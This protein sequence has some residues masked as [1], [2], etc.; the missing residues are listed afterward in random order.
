MNIADATSIAG[1][2]CTQNGIQADQDRLGVLGAAL[3]GAVEHDAATGRHFVLDT[4]GTRIARIRDGELVEIDPVEWLFELTKSDSRRPARRT[5]TPP[6][7][8]TDTAPEGWTTV[9]FNASTGLR[10]TNDPMLGVIQSIKADQ[11]APLLAEMQT[12][13]NPYRPGPNFNRTRQAVLTNRDPA[14]AARFKAEV[15]IPK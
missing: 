9:K 15:G 4:D 7:V 12:W 14:R 3:A 2:F 11:D 8:P 10:R 13:P 5:P 6:P 1:Q